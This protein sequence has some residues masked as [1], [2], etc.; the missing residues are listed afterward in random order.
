MDKFYTLYI[1]GNSIFKCELTGSKED[2]CCS[3]AFE[4]EK[5]Y[6]VI[7]KASYTLSFPCG[8]EFDATLFEGHS[9]LEDDKVLFDIIDEYFTGLYKN[10]LKDAL[11]DLLNKFRNRYMVVRK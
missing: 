11:R 3:L 10:A 1:L 7:L 9:L 8:K 5:K 4:I 2:N 6:F